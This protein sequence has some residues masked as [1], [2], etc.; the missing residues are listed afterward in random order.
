MRKPWINRSA[1]TDF[2]DKN[3]RHVNK[4]D[5]NLTS[6]YRVFGSA[7]AVGCN[8]VRCCVQVVG[9]VRS[10]RHLKALLI[11]CALLSFG[12]ARPGFAHDPALHGFKLVTFKKP[13]AAPGIVLNDV[14]D[15]QQTLAALKG[16]FVL[17]NFWATW[18]PPCLE[19]MPSMQVL[20][21]RY[22]V[23]G[24]SVVAIS[25]DEEGKSVVAPFIDKLGIKFAVW[26]DSDRS[27]SDVYGAKNLPVT[28]LLNREGQ[29]IA[30][31]TG[32]RDWSSEAALSTLDELIR[33]P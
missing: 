29:V 10:I 18:C 2:A 8:F 14:E 13:F 1:M 3:T 7:R 17:L 31:A 12:I 22:A 23:D 16:K 11:V 30:A 4:R 28:F 19:E 9:G 5:C 27:T 32:K 24:F 6:L 33:K 15:R 26:L 25:S 21:D 20:H